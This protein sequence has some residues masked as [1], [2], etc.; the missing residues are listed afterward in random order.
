MI[1]VVSAQVVTARQGVVRVD[2]LVVPEEAA[3]PSR[4]ITPVTSLPVQTMTD[5]RSRA[6]LDDAFLHA[7]Y[8]TQGTE[9][10]RDNVDNAEVILLVARDE[11]FSLLDII[12]I[13]VPPAGK[14]LYWLS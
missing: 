6:P 13:E 2:G 4:I 7:K 3:G 14:E 11:L 10:V 1:G 12:D 8:I 5:D 9:P